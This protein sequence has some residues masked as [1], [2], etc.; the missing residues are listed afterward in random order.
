MGRQIVGDAL[1]AE[2]GMALFEK[3]TN[4]EMICD[5]GGA[6][7][8]KSATDRRI[9][10]MEEQSKA[11]TGKDNKKLRTELGKEISA[12]RNSPAYVDACKIAKGGKPT[13][14]HFCSSPVS[15]PSTMAPATPPMAPT[16]L[17]IMPAMEPLE[18]VAETSKADKKP[19]KVESAGLS[20]EEKDELEKLREQI[21]QRKT[22]LKEQG[23]SGGQQNKDEEVVKWVTRM[24]ALKEKENPGSTGKDSKADKKTK[25]KGSLSIEEMQKLEQLKFEFDEYTNRLKTEFGYTKKD[26]AKDPDWME[27]SAQLKLLEGRA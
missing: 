22:Q 11:L 8:F 12:L 4:A 6:E 2:Q 20:R 5:T 16:P 25:K 26:I 14:G 15:T 1:R 18:P 7:A 24:N 23:L 3:S 17:E 9:A 13:H 21:I 10:A 27:M 19:K